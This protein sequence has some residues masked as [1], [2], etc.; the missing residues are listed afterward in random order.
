M[1]TKSVVV[2]C[3]RRASRCVAGPPPTAA[4]PLLSARGRPASHCRVAVEPRATVE[5]MMLSSG[6]RAA[7]AGRPATAESPLPSARRLAAIAAICLACLAP[8]A[9][10]SPGARAEKATQELALADLGFDFGAVDAPVQVVEFS[11]YACGYCRRF[12]LETFP[13]LQEFI[14]SGTVRWKYVTYASGMFRNGMPAAYAAEC[15]GEQ[16]V[17]EEVSRMLYERQQRWT[18]LLDASPAFEEIAREAGADDAE[19]QA[20]VAEARPRERVQ[21]AQAVAA[22]LGVS[23][24]PFFLV[25]GQPLMGAQPVEFWRDVIRALVARGPEGDARGS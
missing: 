7:R 21:S 24:T 4:S 3:R 15:A 23:G 5:S 16:G 18:R 19:F 14:D 8:A 22:R 1:A 12:H 20:C 11:D 6:T 10:G 17:F 13:L 9:C 2:A 25:N